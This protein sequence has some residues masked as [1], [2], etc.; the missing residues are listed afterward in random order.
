MFLDFPHN[1]VLLQ[2]NYF[3]KNSDHWDE[4]LQKYHSSLFEFDS[5]KCL[6]VIF[7]IKI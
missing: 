5:D 7:H 6:S 3:E 4:H 1:Y 2:M